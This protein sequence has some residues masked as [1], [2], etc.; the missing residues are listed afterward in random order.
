MPFSNLVVSFT[1]PP[2]VHKCLS[3]STFSPVLLLV[4]ILVI[5]VYMQIYHNVILICIS[6]ITNKVEYLSTCFH[7][8][9]CKVSLQISHPFIY[10][11]VYLFLIAFLIEFLIESQYYWIFYWIILGT[12]VFYQTFAWQIFP[13]EWNAFS[14]SYW[15]SLM[16]RVFCFVF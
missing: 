9:C 8:L 16:N 1:S 11:F 4:F 12:W 10:W 2:A 13:M 15:C 7:I 3:C 6:L 14:L 5:L